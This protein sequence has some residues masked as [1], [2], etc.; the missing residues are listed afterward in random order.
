MEVLREQVGGQRNL[1]HFDMGTFLQTCGRQDFA[2][3]QHELAAIGV[4]ILFHLNVPQ[5]AIHLAFQALGNHLLPVAASDDEQEKRNNCKCHST[6]MSHDSPPWFV[7]DETRMAI[8]PCAAHK[9]LSLR[10]PFR[11]SL[12]DADLKTRR[13][14]T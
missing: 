4:W 14:H 5:I 11:T 3:R 2:A 10:F 8:A 9:R 6:Q 12:Q 13:M 1:Q 7:Q